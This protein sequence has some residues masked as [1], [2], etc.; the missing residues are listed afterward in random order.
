MAMNAVIV[1]TMTFYHIITDK[2]IIRQIN[3]NYI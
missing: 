1:T 2:Y 3:L